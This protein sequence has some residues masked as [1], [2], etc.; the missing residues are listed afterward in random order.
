MKICVCSIAKYP[1]CHLAIWG[2]SERMDWQEI[3][4]LSIVSGVCLWWLI[5]LMRPRQAGYQQKMVCGGC[6]PA[7]SPASP[8]SVVVSSRKGERPVIFVRRT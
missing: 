3:A 2:Y 1:I 5:R 7:L 8:P 6:C 4:A